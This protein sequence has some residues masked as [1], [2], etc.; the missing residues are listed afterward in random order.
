MDLDGEPQPH[1]MIQQGPDEEGWETVSVR[2]SGR[3]RAP[4]DRFVG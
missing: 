4:V 3:R 1:K 2:R